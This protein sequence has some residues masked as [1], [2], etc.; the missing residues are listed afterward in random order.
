MSWP[1]SRRL[2]RRERGSD[3]RALP[4]LLFMLFT[5]LVPCLPLVAAVPA[6]AQIIEDDAYPATG[7]AKGYDRR[8]AYVGLQ[9]FYALENFDSSIPIDLDID[10]EG[11][12]TGGLSVLAGYRASSRVAGE[13]L[14]QY[15]DQFAL[16]A[17]L[18]TPPP[19]N[20]FF[21]GWSLTGNAKLFALK[22]RVQPYA[23]LGLGALVLD[24]EA[25]NDASF[26][27]RFG[28]GLDFYLNT[29]WVLDV[30]L[31]YVLPTGSLSDF[32]ILTIGAGA[33]YRF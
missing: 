5:P 25:G 32:P 18:P 21:G 30:E 6:T 28:A 13:L 3:R 2:A 22:G 10:I 24:R 4:F 26:A 8:G 1:M 7:P 29:H 23:V 11:G 27:A 31:G 20:E 33:Q 16:K 9:G 12:D 15:Y 17:T 19:V 14:F